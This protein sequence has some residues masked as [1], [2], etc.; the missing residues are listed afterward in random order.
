MNRTFPVQQ[1]WRALSCLQAV[2]AS[3][4]KSTTGVCMTSTQI[5]VCGAWMQTNFDAFGIHRHLSPA[6]HP[7]M[8]SALVGVRTTAQLS[9]R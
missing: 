5:A 2:M 7:R 6:A 8:I 1:A 9:T 3:C 4:Y